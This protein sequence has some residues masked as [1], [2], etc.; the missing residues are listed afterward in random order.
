MNKRGF[1]VLSLGFLLSVFAQGVMAQFSIAGIVKDKT[2]EMPLPKVSVRLLSA[3]DSTFVTGV[4]SKDNGSF[5]LNVTKAGKYIAAFSYLGY[6]TTYQPVQ[7]TTS[8]R[9]QNIGSILLESNDILL[10]EAV[11]I[12]K[13]PEV[14]VKE[15]TVEF[16]ADS[17]KTQPNSVVEDLLKKLPGVEV[18][19]E[20]KITHAGKEITK[21]LVDGKEFFSDDPKVATKNLPVDIVE[22]LQV[23]DR[24]SDLARLTGVD[25]GE[26]ETVINLTIKEGMKHGWFGNISGGY[27][28]DGRY[29]AGAMINRFFG[30]NQVTILAG[31]NN[32]NNMGFTDMGGGR[33]RR[34]GGMNGINT[35]HNVGINFN[36]G[37][38]EIFRVGGDVSYNN[39]N[40][41]VLQRTERQNLFADSTSYYSGYNK[42]ND[43]G[44][45]IRG[46]FRMRWNIDSL[47]TI[48]FRP[49][50][51][52][53]LS[54]SDSYD[55]A[56][57]TAGDLARSKVNFSESNN[58]NKGTGYDLS[59]EIIYNHKFRSRP[60]RSFSIQAEYKF[61][62]TQED[63]W[64]KALYEYY[65]LGTDSTLDQ[66]DD[67]HTWSNSYGTRL[68]WTEPLGDVTKGRFL[69]FSYR[70]KANFNNADKYTYDILTSPLNTQPYDTV[71]NDELSN[72][73]RNDYLMH[74]AQVGFKQVKP[75]Y[76]YD[77]GVAVE[78]SSSQSIDLIN[79]DRNIPKRTV[80]NVAP[81]LR[82]R[83]KM[84][85]Q[86]SLRI[87]YRGSSS[88]PTMTQLQP[89][90]DR[91]DPLR[92]VVGNPELKPSFQ[93]RLN[94]R[95]NDYDQASQRA[96]MAMINAGFTTNSIISETTYDDLT[97]GQR[98]TYRNVNGV[99]NASGM[100]MYSTPF[101]NKHWQLNS[102]SRL[103][104][105]NNV[106]YNN[107]MRND[108][109]S[110]N[111]IENL[112]L[113]FRSDYF[114]AE[115]R[116]NYR[117]LLATNSMQNQ[118]DQSTHNYG[119][120]FN[121]NGYLP[122]SITLGTD[123][124]YSG[125]SGYSAGYNTESW[126]WNAQASYQFLKGK[127]ATIALK[128]YDI[129]GQRNSIRRTIT[130]NYIQDVEYNTL[131]TYG[132]ITFTYRFNT[133]GDKRPGG[134]RFDR[135]PHG[136]GPPPGPPGRR[137]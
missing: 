108:A 21:I 39:S 46:N 95:F 107:G 115:L 48:E 69:T 7:L 4:S 133:F 61:S 122:W 132:L 96:I 65:Q 82:Y 43:H 110:F 44:Q 114:D 75:N 33:F 87:D 36:V 23:V 54:K 84:G 26:E 25:D 29:E 101:R 32:T 35:S 121:V 130:G 111:A 79:S 15:D 20:G 103:S 30:D 66:M 60:G 10:S 124:T 112:G 86:R 135:G 41:N 14:V 131:N 52:V 47:N 129:L 85:K 51:A 2:D 70:F 89:V 56:L 68:T 27:G 106:G 8:Q 73:F 63:G 105:N 125:S 64:T 88:Q 62:D 53:A 113:S 3:K 90:E 40:R 71:R 119:G 93:N 37:K 22:K 78:P 55:S 98:T 128:V 9:R 100:L 72:S 81:Y 117:Y 42:M 99:W 116:G 126:L 91:S 109:G 49:R 97:G 6:K 12:G 5:A 59:G 77:V 50:F 104:Y 18:D 76:T 58:Y 136:F 11:V 83:Y 31:S 1:L 19:S 16:N 120:T 127:N 94:V 134:E 38:E 34:F 92:I 137:F 45:N 123:I 80:F 17:Y 118:S 13:A 102:F 74:R 24:K 57:T 67:N 28:P